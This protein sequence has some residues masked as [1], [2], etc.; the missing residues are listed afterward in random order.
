MR[1][2]DTYTAHTY[3]SMGDTK[4]DLISFLGAIFR[5]AIV[6]TDVVTKGD[7]KAVATIAILGIFAIIAAAV[8]LPAMPYTYLTTSWYYTGSVFVI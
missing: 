4:L 2:Y 7:R 6:V 8:L 1:V 3:R 5:L